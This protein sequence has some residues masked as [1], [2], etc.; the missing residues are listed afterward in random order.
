MSINDFETERTDYYS[1]T[2]RAALVG[3]SVFAGYRTYAEASP[4]QVMAPFQERSKAREAASAVARAGMTP[5]ALRGHG[6]STATMPFRDLLGDTRGFYNQARRGRPSRRIGETELVDL[7]R[8]QFPEGT[9]LPERIQ[10]LTRSMKGTG[11]RSPSLS[12]DYVGDSPARINVQSALGGR[13]IDFAIPL[14]SRE[15]SIFMGDDLTTRF[16]ASRVYDPMTTSPAAGMVGTKNLDVAITEELTARMQGIAQ[17]VESPRNI[18]RQAMSAAVYEEGSFNRPGFAGVAADSALGELKRSRIVVDPFQAMDREGRFQT[19][20]QL[21]LIEGY[22]GGTASMLSKGVILDKDSI[23]HRSIPGMDYSPGA[24]QYIRESA[25]DESVR[26]SVDWFGGRETGVGQ[27]RHAYIPDEEMPTFMRALRHHY[28]EISELADEE[29]LFSGRN[30]GVRNRMYTAKINL[31]HGATQS[32]QA[33]INR[34]AQKLGVSTEE[35][36][37][38]A[39]Q[40]GGLAAA[41]PEFQRA[42]KQVDITED[43][44][45]TIG[46]LE[47]LTKQ[48]RDARSILRDMRR[49]ESSFDPLAIERVEQRVGFLDEQIATKRNFVRD[50]GTLGVAEDMSSSTKLKGQVLPQQVLNVTVGR[51]NIMSIAT[52]THYDVREGMKFFGGIKSTIKGTNINIPAV[53][54][55]HEHLMAGGDLMSMEELSRTGLPDEF[56]GVDIIG[57]ESPVKGVTASSLEARRVPAAVSGYIATAIQEGRHTPEELRSLGVALEGGQYRAVEQ[58]DPK[59]T[60]RRIQQLN[61]GRGLDDILMGTKP[62]VSGIRI[63]ET[64]LSPDIHSVQSGFGGRGTISERA[65]YNLGAMGLGKTLDDFAGDSIQE[66]NRMRAL[67]RVEEGI[68]AAGDPKVSALRASDVMSEGFSSSLFDSDLIRRGEFIRRVSDGRDTAY[69]ELGRSVKGIERIPVFSTPDLGGY[70]GSPASSGAE[71][72]P[73]LDR[74][75]RN[76]ISA[77]LMTGPDADAVLEARAEDYLSEVKKTRESLAKSAMR[78]KPKGSLFG[79][80]AGSIGDMD[81]IATE[82]GRKM[83]LREGVRAPVVA[84]TR[85]DISSRFGEDAIE[86]ALRGDLFGLLTRE[87]V[88]GAHSTAPVNIRIAEEMTSGRRM[89]AM[90]DMSGRIFVAGQSIAEG[91]ANAVRRGLGL[92]FDKDPL[93]LAVPKS[94]EAQRELA[95]FM[96]VGE[97][98]QSIAGREYYRSIE[99][100][101]DLSESFKGKE[102]I[103]FLMDNPADFRRVLAQQKELEKHAI[104]AISN[105]FKNVHT[106]LREELHRGAGGVGDYRKFYLGEDL[107]HAF[108]ENIL[109]SKHQ[110]R[111]ALLGNLSGELMDA[112]RSEGAYRRASINQRA[113]AV[114]S[115]FDQLAWGTQEEGTRI[116]EAGLASDAPD[117][118]RTYRQVTDLENVKNMLRARETGQSFLREGGVA[119]GTAQEMFGQQRAS[120]AAM[121]MKESTKAAS[122]TMSRFTSNLGRYAILPAAGIG[123]ASSVMSRPNVVSPVEEAGGLHDASNDVKGNFGKTRFAIPEEKVDNVMVK[124]RANAGSDLSAIDG[125]SQGAG[126]NSRTSLTDL[127]SKPNIYDLEDM[128]EKGY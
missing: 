68:S 67:A 78:L 56:R 14:V 119:Q 111:G 63:S 7:L 112:M 31:D 82:M 29:V 35:V 52:E 51:D 115:I 118:F 2:G 117:R 127:R 28:P 105:E 103:N 53:L 46:E 1:L 81:E 94:P 116:R 47:G 100:M 106:G 27:F 71:M 74:A 83:G 88:E 75:S 22:Q 79:Q 21:S 114:Q 48:R 54:A 85:R 70:I 87:P 8:G 125:M 108:V 19:A 62:G 30:V 89:G 66:A 12:L 3:G 121:A 110:T 18:V 5:T 69:V 98:Q 9:V 76:L 77:S 11:M 20:K 6:V 32:A 84:L 109:K 10:Q 73:H 113:E 96:G 60:I 102:S 49:S 120:S 4:G 123:L 61:P 65:V 58:I 80:A 37:R 42:L 43:Y 95:D 128:I 57:R 23:L 101:S 97:R 36:G 93:N 91:M 50:F 126:V 122:A 16:A 59:E 33:I 17:G 45:A 90:G 86:R 92:D 64:L 26:P 13:K 55:Q 25:F 72:M 34:I 41:G 24:S 124:G 39:A 107:S 99:R 44:R 15:G 104:G 40:E 38:M